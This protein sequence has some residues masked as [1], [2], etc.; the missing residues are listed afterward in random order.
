SHFARAAAEA[1]SN[2]IVLDDL[3]AGTPPPAS[4][5]VCGDIG[6]RA[7]VARLVVE[8]RVTAVAHFAGKIAVGESVAHPALYYHLNVTRALALLEVVRDYVPTF[9]YSST[10]AVYGNPER[11]PILEDAPTMPIN[12]YG[13]TKLAFER[14]LA[15]S[16][17]RWAALRYFNAAGAHPDG[18]M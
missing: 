6:D 7:L 15:D 16:G 12:P 9:L 2:V 14:A 13:E 11:V 18:T 10:A 17:L 5:F 1:G 8:H 4:P 3:S